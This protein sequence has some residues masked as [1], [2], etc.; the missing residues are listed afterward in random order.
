M[1]EDKKDGG[2]VTEIAKAIGQIVD[3]VPVYEDALQ[4]A[5]KELGKG[6]AVVAKAV[7]AA[8][9]PVEGLIWG[10]DK[11][12]DFVRERVAKKLE[13][14]PP[15]EIQQPKPHIAV[16]AIEALRYTG[17][18]ESLSDLY[19]NLLAT[20]MD[21]ATAY[22]AH[23]G[24]VDIIKNM[25]PD[26]AKVMKYLVTAWDFIAIASIHSNIENGG[27]YNVL[28]RNV[29][30]LATRAQ[31]EHP[32]LLSTYLDNLDRL[33]LIKVDY[34][35]FLTDPKAYEE[36]ESAAT[37][38]EI[39]QRIS[40]TPGRKGEIKKGIVKMTDLGSQFGRACILDKEGQ[41]RD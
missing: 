37:V 35:Q 39:L 10:V 7:N 17:A 31:C 34:D 33:G 29:T 22:R 13:N 24:F 3:K 6:L 38:Q 19:A 9:A 1:A 40:Q 23:P 16:P 28:H 41:P 36:I 14:V 26:E 20:S 2:S 11:I 25:C 32:G 15:G 27:G 30:S 18:E 5:A 4:P 21:K 12:K 8:L